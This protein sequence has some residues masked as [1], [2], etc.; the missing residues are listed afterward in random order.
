MAYKGSRLVAI[1]VTVSLLPIALAAAQS[2]RKTIPV[3]E[4]YRN[5]CARCHGAEGRGDTAQ[6]EMYHAPDFTDKDWWRKNPSFKR[7]STLTSIVTHGK[8]EMPAFGKKLS[9]TEI[10]QL[11]NYVRR[12]GR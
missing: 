6:G 11:V 7:N 4:L 5:N 3:E 10:K 8:E 1:G 12:F 2:K 9:P